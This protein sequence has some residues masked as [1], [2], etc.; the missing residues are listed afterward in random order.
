MF[1]FLLHKQRDAKPDPHQV[2]QDYLPPARRED[3]FFNPLGRF[4]TAVKS[5]VY[6]MNKSSEAT[7]AEEMKEQL[8]QVAV[9]AF[10]GP[11]GTGKSTQAIK[12]ARENG[13]NYIID[14]GILIYGSRIIAGSSAKRAATKIES[15]KNAIF[16]DETQALNMRRVLLEELPPALM[17]LGTSRDMVDR[18]CRNLG[19]QKPAMLIRIEDIASEEE[20]RTAKEIRMTEGTHT[21]PVPSMEIRHEFSGSLAEPLKK[22]KRR[23]DRSD[24]DEVMGESERTVVRPTFS[25]LGSYSISDEAMAQLVTIVLKSISGIAEVKDFRSYKEA[26]GVVLEIKLALFYGYAAQDILTQAQA[27]LTRQIEKLTSINI[28]RINL[29]AVN[30]VKA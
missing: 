20:R 10:V 28:L 21:I 14:D 15:V 24:K 11:S 7:A 19:L 3:I 17:I 27:L 12:V 26:H 30:L 5:T 16:S 23:W 6:E 9:V 2:R 18:I 29:Q 1:E 25:T 22:L 4:A 13:I 8:A